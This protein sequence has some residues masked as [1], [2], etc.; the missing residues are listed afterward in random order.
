MDKP[1]SPEAYATNVVDQVLEGRHARV[2]SMGVLA[3][4]ATRMGLPEIDI[5]AFQDAIRR[6]MR[7]T[8]SEKFMYTF[9]ATCSDGPTLANKIAAAGIADGQG[10]G[11]QHT[12]SKRNKR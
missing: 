7:F 4:M 5:P 10:G 2:V 8:G 3:A 9:E 6:D 12:R 1:N 11:K